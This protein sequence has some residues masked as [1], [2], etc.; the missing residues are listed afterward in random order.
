MSSPLSLRVLAE[1]FAVARF[2]ADAPLPDWFARGPLASASWTDDELSIVCLQAQVPPEVR[3]ERRWR[4]LKLQGPFPF[5]L[6][7]ILL[8]VLQPL[9]TA[10]IGI[11]AISTFDT[12]Y[13]LVKADAMERAIVALQTQGHSVTRNVGSD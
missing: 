13:V 9:A 11:F 8:S 10:D 6:T 12:D 2:A 3:C 5:Q 1:E 4:C 7:G